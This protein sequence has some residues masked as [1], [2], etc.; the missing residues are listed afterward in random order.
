MS[1]ELIE[2]KMKMDIWDESIEEWIQQLTAEEIANLIS[3]AKLK[4]DDTLIKFMKQSDTN[5]QH[6]IQSIENEYTNV[7]GRSF[8]AYDPFATF[9]YKVLNESF[10]YVIKDLAANILRY[11]ATDVNRFSAQGLVIK[12]KENGIEPMLEEILDS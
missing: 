6:I 1:K 11:I 12:I 3:E 5:A 4:S 8:K 10:P 7:C 2:T 9:A